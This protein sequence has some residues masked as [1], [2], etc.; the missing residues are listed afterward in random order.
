MT[1]IFLVKHVYL[2]HGVTKNVLSNKYLYSIGL[3]RKKQ[4]YD[5]H[6]TEEA[7]S[8]VFIFK[9]VVTVSNFKM[10]P[11]SCTW[12]HNNCALYPVY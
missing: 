11:I 4:F 7:I 10:L 3:K 6:N 12:V 9:S 2:Y 8:F 5:Q 1:G